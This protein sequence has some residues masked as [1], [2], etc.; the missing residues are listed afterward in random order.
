MTRMTARELAVQMA[1][2]FDFASDVEEMLDERLCGCF[3]EDLSGE[4]EFFAEKPDRKQEAYIRS[5][6]RGA[7]SRL[8]ELDGYI[9]EHAVGWKVSRM[10]RVAVAVMRICLYEILYRED[11]PTAAAINAAV[12]IAKRYEPE[13][14]VGF[15]NGILGSFTRSGE[16]T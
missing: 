12:E 3:F 8:E 13:E 11:V 5:V 9:K 15:I 1:Y 14:V 6:V 4:D 7:H 10:P 16:A 2:A